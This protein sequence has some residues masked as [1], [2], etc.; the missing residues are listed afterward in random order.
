MVK[1][2]VV[3]ATFNEEK[4][5]GGCLDSVKEI[6][7]EIV[8]VDGTSTDHTVE[9]AKRFEARVEI[10]ENHPIFHINKQK[11]IEMAK[12]EWILQLDADERVSHELGT[13]IKRIIEMN[14]KELEEYQKHL[15]KRELFLRHQTLLEKRDGKIGMEEGGYVAFFFPRKNYFLGRY[16]MYG[17]VYPDGVIRL[18]KKNKA[19]LPAKDVHEQMVVSGKVGWLQHDLLHIDSPTFGKYIM[20][21]NRY[22]GLIARELREERSRNKFGMTKKLGTSLDY[23][24]IKPLWWFMLTFGRHKGFLD[25]WQGFVFSFFS[26]LRFP[27]GYL[28]YLFNLKF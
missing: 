17:G 9:I 14:E 24:L 7:D 26:A 27:L 10:T 21:W 6:A 4:M 11:A 5:L 16:L 8:I 22:T 23:L 1:L 28:K 25:G 18:V 19:Y 20:R 15:P 13:E 12:Y 2:S 3:L